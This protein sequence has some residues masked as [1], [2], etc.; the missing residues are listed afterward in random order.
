MKQTRTGSAELYIFMDCLNFFLQG[1]ILTPV[2][3][4]SI[5]GGTLLI[6]AAAENA[7]MV[8]MVGLNVGGE[9]LLVLGHV[10]TVRTLVHVGV[11]AHNFGLDYGVQGGEVQL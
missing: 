2:L 3:S 7:G 5:S 11:E 6:A 9:V 8:D 10:G 1:V 4:Q